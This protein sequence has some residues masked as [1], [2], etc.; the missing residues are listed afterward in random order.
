MLAH[1]I[2]NQD[3]KNHMKT[4]RTITF[5]TL[6]AISFS[7]ALPSYKVPDRRQ[8][9]QQAMHAAEHIQHL[10]QEPTH[11]FQ[12][13]HAHRYAGHSV[14]QM[15]T[16]LTLMMLL[17]MVTAKMS[18]LPEEAWP[19]SV[20][21]ASYK[22]WGPTRQAFGPCGEYIPNPSAP[23]CSIQP[24]SAVTCCS[25]DP[26]RCIS[27]GVGGIIGD[28]TNV[29]DFNITAALVKAEKICNSRPH[30]HTIAEE[31]AAFLRPLRPIYEQNFNDTY[32]TLDIPQ[33]NVPLLTFDM[34]GRDALSPS[35][36]INLALISENPSIIPTLQ[37]MVHQLAKKF[38]V[39]EP[40]I[41]V[42]NDEYCS[43][44]AQHTASMMTGQVNGFVISGIMIPYSTLLNFSDDEIADFLGHEV[45]HLKQYQVDHAR[46]S[47]IS[48]K[49][50]NNRENEADIASV[51]ANE[52]ACLAVWIKRFAWDERVDMWELFEAST[53]K[54]TGPMLQAV[55][56]LGYLYPPRALR[57]ASILLISESYGQVKEL[58]RLTAED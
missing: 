38:H 2:Y 9:Q 42:Y 37:A 19:S 17:P 21:R 5:F 16:I 49:T 47:L 58:L 14:N 46:E 50:G 27:F 45:W 32:C 48:M 33:P 39:Y 22:D 28:Q 54:N 24:N 13:R 11:R 52:N 4:L 40:A 31:T 55:I 53:R 35:C 18:T 41:F 26:S 36:K 25:L 51:L 15:L 1:N 8:Q 44:T 6:I 23:C 7:H 29:S 34:K 56:N 57:M 20:H 30:Q 12:R 3:R 43:R 10:S